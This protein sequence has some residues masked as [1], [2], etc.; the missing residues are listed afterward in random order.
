MNL[1]SKWR[2]EDVIFSMWSFTGQTH[3]L[4]PYDVLI[5]TFVAVNS[6]IIIH[7]QELITEDDR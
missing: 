6:I 5:P 3:S 2:R 4:L 7:Y 1:V